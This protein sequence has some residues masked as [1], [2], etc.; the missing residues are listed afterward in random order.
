V[1]VAAV[2]QGLYLV[3]ANA[4]LW[5]SVGQGL[6]DRKPEKFQISWSSA[7]TFWPGRIHLEEV[8]LQ[9][10]SRR[11][12][13]ELELD[14]AVVSCSLPALALKRFSTRRIAGH[15]LEFRLLRRPEPGEPRPEAGIVP[16][17]SGFPGPLESPARDEPPP[18]RRWPWKLALSGIEVDGVR[19]VWIE[20]QRFVG[21]GRASGGVR[22]EIRGPA[23]ISPSIV[24]LFDGRIT[25]GDEVVSEAAHLTFEARSER[26]LPRENRGLAALAFLSGR[27]RFESPRTG[28]GFLDRYFQKAPWVDVGG[29]GDVRA[30]VTFDHGK[31]SP[32][33][34][35]TV[36]SRDLAVGALD[37]RATGSGELRAEVHA[38]TATDADA[39]AVETLL[40]AVL[41]EFEIAGGDGPPLVRGS[42]LDLIAR[43]RKADLVEGFG[44]LDVEVTIPS[45][46]IPDLSAFNTFLPPAS[47]LRFH[48]GHGRLQGR[49]DLDSRKNTGHGELEVHADGV[50]LKYQDTAMVGDV[51]ATARLRGA[52]LVGRRY[53]VSGSRVELDRFWVADASRTGETGWWGKFE[54]REG[55]LR[56]RG[57]P[58]I[59]A[60]L[61]ARIRD[62]GPLAAYIAEK[63]PVLRWFENL[64]TV[65]D[66]TAAGRLA[67]GA[68]NMSVTGVEITGEKLEILATALHLTHG[69]RDGLFHFQLG[70]LSAG[71]EIAGSEREWKLLRSRRWYEQRAAEASPNRG[72]AGRSPRRSSRPEPR[73]REPGASTK[74]PP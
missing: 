72:P 33:S 57:N 27:V 14:R 17:I 34:V 21:N 38:S 50:G 32:G 60:V 48:S 58:G 12:R 49:L 26:Y 23:E 67:I 5:T 66:V 74:G 46:E 54:L 6:L 68:E 24:E 39:D 16:Q 10:Q 62:S 70:P 69:H 2:L 41:H 19:E 37:F 11:A 15:G 18:Q 30:D 3:A 65:D 28:F 8:R 29:T 55:E 71:V 51:R 45:S 1:L 52:D 25:Q 20:G 22:I 63:K 53:D 31:L 59:E 73:P 4:F 9:S 64:L 13:W 47:D 35:V 56:G 43:G 36:E 7:R 61:V 40:Q 42:G 44:N